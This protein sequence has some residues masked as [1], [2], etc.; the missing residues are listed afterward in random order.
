[1]FTTANIGCMERKLIILF[2]VGIYYYFCIS[3]N[4]NINFN[5]PNLSTQEINKIVDIIYI[6][7]GSDKTKYPYG[8]KSISTRNKEHARQICYNTVRNNY[9]RWKSSSSEKDFI[10]F[11]GDRYCPKEADKKGNEHWIKNLK[12]YLSK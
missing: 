9:V 8:I 1:M 6:I 12:Y 11:L 4:A 7:E 10:T 3:A 5:N 2:Y